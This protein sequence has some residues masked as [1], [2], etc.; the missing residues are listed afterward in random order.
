MQLLKEKDSGKINCC[1]ATI[2]TLNID[3]DFMF[4]FLVLQRQKDRVK[5]LYD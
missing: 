2:V 3:A 5:F 1:N 4:D